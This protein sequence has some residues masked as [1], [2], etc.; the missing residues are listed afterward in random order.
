MFLC[1]AR[2]SLWR[3]GIVFCTVVFSG[4][5][6]Y[7]QP[8]ERRFVFEVASVKR[9]PPERVSG[10]GLAVRARKIPVCLVLPGSH[11]CLL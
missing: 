5:A 3:N 9:A 7:A 10:R 11:C 4:S 2:A 8:A 1:Q 6:R